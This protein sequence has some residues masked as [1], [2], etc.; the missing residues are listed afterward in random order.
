MKNIAVLFSGGV[1][2]S[3]SLSLLKEAGY[4]CTAFYLKIW[5]EDELSYLGDCPWKE[6]LFYVEKTC[7]QLSVPLEIVSLQRSYWEKVVEKSIDQIKNGYTPN[8]DILCNRQV[9]FGAFLDIYGKDIDM[10]ATGHYA[11][12]YEKEDF[13]YLKM[14]DDLLKDQTYFLAY[15]PKA[16]LDRVLFPLGNLIKNE[17]RLYAE[18]HFLPSALRKDSQGVC[19]L[20]KIKFKD[21]IEHHLGEK[22]GDLIEW[23][24]RKKVGEHRGFWFYT[25]GQRQGIKLSGGPWYVVSKNINENVVYVSKVYYESH[26]LRNNFYLILFNWLVLEKDRPIECSKVFIKLRHGASIEEAVIRYEENRINITL[27][28]NDQGIANGQFGVLYNEKKICLGAGIIN[29][30]S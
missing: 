15:T 1:D 19:F 20:G 10:V 18:K 7:K 11:K 28:K 27:L 3:V 17:V 21:F 16:Q 4:S 14:T 6:D 25:I 8:P 29:E 23:E 24:S 5:L 9:K 22:K 2:S 30:Q 12:R 13:I 26:L